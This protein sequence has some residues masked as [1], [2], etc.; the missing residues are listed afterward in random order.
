[1]KKLTQIA[2]AVAA[3]SAAVDASAAVQSYT[4]NSNVI[5]NAKGTT[6][7]LDFAKFN[8][9]LGSL[10]SVDVQLFSDL[11]TTVRVENLS[12]SSASDITAKAGAVLTFTLTGVTQTLNQS[13]TKVFNMTAFDTVSDFAGTSGAVYS[14][15]APLT[16]SASYSTAP[17][18]SLF[19]GTGNL[20]AGLAGAPTIAFSDTAGN[21]RTVPTAAFNGYAKVTYNYVTT[22]VPEPETYAML[23]AGLGL[24]GVVARRRKSA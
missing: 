10:Q 17:V 1:M 16:S 8:A 7:G 18:L 6:A 11:K 19:T 5:A 21:T 22:A 14:F 15:N 4:V 23:L 12:T 3:L 9:S 24:V 13:A 20:H 2:L